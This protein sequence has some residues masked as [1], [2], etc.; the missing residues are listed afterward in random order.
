LRD[1]LAQS[2]DVRHVVEK[3]A[4]NT[5]P[6]IPLKRRCADLLGLTR[7]RCALRKGSKAFKRT[8]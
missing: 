2:R 3:G 6:A 4:H 1:A 7:P 8:T 5:G